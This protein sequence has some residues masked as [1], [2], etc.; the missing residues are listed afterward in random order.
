[1]GKKDSSV[2]RTLGVVAVK[3]VAD[4]IVVV[5]GQ[6]EVAAMKMEIGIALEGH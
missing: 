4:G 5:E 3:T 1:M 2:G 6:I